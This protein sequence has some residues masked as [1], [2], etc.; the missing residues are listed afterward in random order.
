RGAPRILNGDV[1]G[2]VWTFRDV[3]DRVRAEEA[4]RQS[5]AR[6][7][8]LVANIPDVIWTADAAGSIL[9]ISPNI[10]AMTGYTAAEII[11][12]GQAGWSECVHPDD[13][14]PRDE[15]RRGT[16]ET[17][18]PFESEYRFQRKDGRWIW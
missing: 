2:R 8:T 9:Y 7:R 6:Y 3:T 4:L 11:A 5:E 12:K 16:F 17:R 1:I 14:L 10:E 15:N 18:Q 13:R